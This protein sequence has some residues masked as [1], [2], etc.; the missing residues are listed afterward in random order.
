MTVEPLKPLSAAKLRD[1]EE[2]VGRVAAIMEG[3]AELTV[4]RV[5]VGPHA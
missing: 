3:T 1:L 4:G 2:Q 5:T